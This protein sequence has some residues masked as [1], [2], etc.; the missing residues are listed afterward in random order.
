TAKSTAHINV[1]S[2]GAAL[3]VAGSGD[4]SLSGAGAGAE[5]H[6]TVGGL[7]EAAVR[8]ADFAGGQQVL[9]PGGLA[10]MASDQATIVSD[11]LAAALSVSASG[12]IAGSLSV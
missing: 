3:S 8:D 6:N 12:S 11:T 5:A 10:V 1:L 9:A 7:I 4:L 2:L